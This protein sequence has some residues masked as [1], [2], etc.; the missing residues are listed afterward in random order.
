MPS[1]SL[2][3]KRK[4]P[5]DTFLK[6]L[7]NTA[8]AVTVIVLLGIIFY[9]LVNGVSYIS[10]KFISTAYSET[11]DDLKG[12]LPMIINTMY[13]VVITLLIS[14]PIGIS[15]AIYLTQYAK[16]GRLVKAIRFT[17]EILSGIPSII[18]GLFGYTV[19]CILFRLQTSLLAGCLTMTLCI[20]PTIIRTTEESLL[21]VPGS[22]K[23]GALA[24]GAGKLRVVMGI[25]LPCAMPGVLTAVILAMGRIVGESAAL[26]FTSGLSYNMPK[27]FVQQI[28][29][30]GRTLT[31]HLYQTA[32]EANSPDAMH[33]A[34]ATASVLLI[35]VFLLNRLAALLSRTLRKG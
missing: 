25:V 33:I 35:L 26:L 21:S 17:T 13:I 9:I 27:G 34:F 28:F 23:E 12:I 6:V 19:F 14:A 5:F 24:L 1:S 18:F 10:W 4:R 16:Q 2:Y 31:L 8:A 22:Y 15:S 20:L 7:I 30:S 29:A 32:R 11:N 3:G